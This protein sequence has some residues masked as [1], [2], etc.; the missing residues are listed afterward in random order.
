MQAA[1][2]G[3]DASGQVAFGA[4]SSIAAYA[5]QHAR[6]AAGTTSSAVEIVVSCCSALCSGHLLDV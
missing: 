5:K 3:P 1:V 4:G 6:V 2:Q